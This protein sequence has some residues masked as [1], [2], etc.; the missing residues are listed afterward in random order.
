MY[1][2]L[3]QEAENSFAFEGLCSFL[4]EGRYG[5]SPAPAV[6]PGMHCSSVLA[7]HVLSN[8]VAVVVGVVLAALTVPGT[9]L[10]GSNIALGL[11][12]QVGI[13]GFFAPSTSAE[14]KLVPL[15][16]VCG[17]VSTL[18]LRD[19]CFTFVWCQMGK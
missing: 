2:G 1:R 10:V 8:Q 19:Q 17:L 14:L 12:T 16:W 15:V 9:A 11:G 4:V 7:G 3:L 5:S 6:A 18:G 13:G